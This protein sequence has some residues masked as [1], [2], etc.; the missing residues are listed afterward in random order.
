MFVISIHLHR[1]WYDS[2]NRQTSVN[3]GNRHDICLSRFQFVWISYTVFYVSIGHFHP[4]LLVAASFYSSLF[5]T[6]GATIIVAIMHRILVANSTE[7]SSTAL[8]ITLVPW[9][10]FMENT[11]DRDDYTGFAFSCLFFLL[12]GWSIWTQNDDSSEKK[13]RQYTV[14]IVMLTASVCSLVQ[15][16]VTVILK[17]IDSSLLQVDP[18]LLKVRGYYIIG[19][20]GFGVAVCLIVSLWF[21]F[22]ILARDVQSQRIS[23]VD[24][25][26]SVTMSCFII[27][28]L[29]VVGVFYANRCRMIVNFGENA[30]WFSA[31]YSFVHVFVLIILVF[32]VV[33][34]KQMSNILFLCLATFLLYFLSSLPISILIWELSA[35]SQYHTFLVR[36]L[37]FEYIPGVTLGL[38]FL[39]SVVWSRKLISR[40]A[41]T[42]P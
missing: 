22:H 33:K 18:D 16:I 29:L 28:I 7:E 23:S 26:L 27:F 40:M 4:D 37:L 41:S 38:S 5:I 1:K 13:H 6:I 8:H 35:L 24:F 34:F 10:F 21:G 12:I 20:H 3:E 39:L 32:V 30:L 9:V 42:E 2:M 31:A 11:I 25:R 17:Y 19:Y 36:W 15:L 14:F